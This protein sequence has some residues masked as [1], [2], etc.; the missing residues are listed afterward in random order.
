MI[1]KNICF[2]GIP[3]NASTS[4]SHSLNI[5]NSHL[6]WNQLQ[7]VSNISQVDIII[8]VFRNPYD[9]LISAY[10]QYIKC[11]LISSTKT[12]NDFVNDLP[13]TIDPE[14]LD[15]LHIAHNLTLHPQSY[16]IKNIDISKKKIYKLKFDNL[17]KDW[18]NLTNIIPTLN[19]IKLEHLN[20]SPIYNITS[21]N[22]DKINKLYKI[23]FNLYNSIL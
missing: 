22:I 13:I 18:N 10:K 7:N 5:D 23:D 9:R 21:N 1:Y 6:S 15:P 12:F 19:N 3:K 4:I 20:I 8:Y 11:E 14:I 17:E 2:I 16:F